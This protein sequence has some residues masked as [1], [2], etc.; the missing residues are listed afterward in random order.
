M[1]KKTILR[2][3][4]E[5]F[6]R[7]MVVLMAVAIVGFAA[8]FI[9]KVNT[10]KTQMAENVTTEASSTKS[11]DELQAMLDEE[12]AA[13]TTQEETTEE[14]T[15]EEPTTEEMTTEEEIISS[16]DKKILVLNSTG[17]AGLAKSW[18]NKLSG[19]GFTNIAT[20]NYSLSSEAQTKIYV[21]EEGMGKDLAEYFSD[22]TIEVG[23]LSSG[24]D[25]S[26][27]GVEIFIVIGK[28]DTTVQ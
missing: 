2:V 22:A 24:I 3:F 12:N 17:V 6:L 11:D 1:D 20:G 7:S 5:A 23:S 16:T 19:E 27:T 18:M 13:D 4:G 15:T 8:F 9:I 25:V 14:V 10:D 21:A 26:T 28:N